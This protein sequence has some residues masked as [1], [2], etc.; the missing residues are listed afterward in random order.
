MSQLRSLLHLLDCSH[1][2]H[3]VLVM[4]YL[5]KKHMIIYKKHTYTESDLVNT[6]QA[7]PVL[8]C[9]GVTSVT[10][11][12][13]ES[14]SHAS[15]SPTHPLRRHVFTAH[16]CRKCKKWRCI[17]A[18]QRA[19]VDKLN[20]QASRPCTLQSSAVHQSIKG[21][22]RKKAHQTDNMKYLITFFLLTTV[23]MAQV[24]KFVYQKYAFKEK[25]SCNTS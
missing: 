11:S 10:T 24:S 18:V 4:M 22:K 6:R 2:F 1:Q 16:Y 7:K 5:L 12:L 21:V 17:V 13:T 23:Y 25:Q 9:T 8:H 20:L 3:I 14:F 15:S 19:F